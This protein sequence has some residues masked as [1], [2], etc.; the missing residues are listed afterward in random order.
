MSACCIEKALQIYIV[1]AF[2][3]VHLK[4]TMIFLVFLL[5][6]EQRN[7]LYVQFES[8]EKYTVQSLRPSV[9]PKIL[10]SQL[11]IETTDPIIMKLGM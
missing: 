4:L 3:A 2:I 10:S 9:R 7:D 5:I 6:D 1:I 8:A 11:V